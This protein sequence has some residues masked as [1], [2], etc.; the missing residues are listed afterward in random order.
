MSQ[1]IINT[2]LFAIAFLLLFGIA[3]LLYHYLKVKVE[4]TRK[5]VHFWNWF[6][7]PHVSSFVR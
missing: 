4:L 1:S 3:E 5:F 7:N 6:T 2:I